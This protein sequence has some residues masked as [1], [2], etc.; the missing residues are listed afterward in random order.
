MQG[1]GMTN[2]GKKDRVWDRAKLQ[3]GMHTGCVQDTA[4]I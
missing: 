1:F 3:G 4:Q 2:T